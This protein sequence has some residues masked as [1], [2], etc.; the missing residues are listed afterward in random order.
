MHTAPN[1]T[2]KYYVTT[3]D[4]HQVEVHLVC[5]HAAARYCTP[6]TA[7]HASL[8]LADRDDRGDDDE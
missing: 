3:R 4:G 6:I 1:H 2:E 5:Q 8:E 7:S